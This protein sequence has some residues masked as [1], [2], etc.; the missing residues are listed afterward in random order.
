MHIITGAFSLGKTLPSDIFNSNQVFEK[1]K[2]ISICAESDATSK[3]IQTVETKKS[4]AICTGYFDQPLSENRKI[5]LDSIVAAY[6]INGELPSVDL[7]GSFQC[8]LFDKKSQRLL[9]F[10]DRG[11]LRTIFYCISENVLYFSTKV[12][13]IQKLTHVAQQPNISQRDFSLIYGFYPENTTVYENVKKLSSGK[14]LSIQSDSFQEI[15]FTGHK[16]FV[17]PNLKSEDEVVEQLYKDLFSAVEKQT[18]GYDRVAVLLGGFDSALIASFLKRLGKEVET[19]TFSFKD[20]SFN[21]AHTDTLSE[22]LDIKHN[23]V[24]IDPSIYV[25]YMSQYSRVFDSPTNWTNYVTQ[26]AYASEQIR[27]D[28]FDLCL[29]G[30]GCDSIFLG[31]PGV[32][33]SSNFYNSISPILKPISKVLVWLMNW[34]L[35]EEK[36]GHVYR[37]ILRI[38]RNAVTD[39]PARTYLMYRIFDETT[40]ARTFN[41]KCYSQVKSVIKSTLDEYKHIIPTETS[42][43]KLAY[44]GR[45]N[46]GPNRAKLSGS[47]DLTGM[48][49]HSPFMHNEI[50]KIVGLYP[51]E[52]LRP[53]DSGNTMQDIGKYILIKMTKK[54]EL[55]PDEII[56]QKK[57]SPVNSPI[58]DWYRQD[59]NEFVLNIIEKSPWSID[60]DFVRKS[61]ILKKT[62]EEI[63]KSKFSADKVTSHSLSLL[64]STLSFY[65]I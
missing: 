63:Y 12:K 65:D 10:S 58:D 55:L 11:A 8:F 47:M 35:L 16:E 33:R 54:F 48:I 27:K 4:F 52:L 45:S 24:K 19:Y 41:E 23:W 5:T 28:G 40:I 36:L 20:S 46:M 61:M 49:I 56:F 34:R 2:I 31:Y 17:I 6:E 38:I 57:D 43:G 42:L 9:L 62:P 39:N 51:D 37:L 25:H 22:Y 7:F 1:H 44:L 32:N 50:K 3:F 26:T 18:E 15:I 53:K 30:D 29:T 21:Q 60:S 14:G 64:V 59:I 13:A